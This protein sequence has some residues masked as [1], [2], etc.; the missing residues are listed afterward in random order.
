MERHVAVKESTEFTK[1]QLDAHESKTPD[2][3][4]SKSTAQE[5]PRD[6]AAHYLLKAWK[7]VLGEKHAT[8]PA[9]AVRESP[10][11]QVTQEAEVRV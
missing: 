1:T 11:E 5:E 4:D 9:Q 6:V 3:E 2:D 7:H 8:R 10:P